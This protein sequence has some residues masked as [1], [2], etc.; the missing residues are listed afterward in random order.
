MNTEKPVVTVTRKLPEKTERRMSE[1]FDARFNENDAPMTHEQLREAMAISDIL[2]VTITDMIDA[3]LLAG[4]GEKLKLIANFGAGTDHIDV[5]TARQ[6]NI[7]VT[8]TPDVFAEDTADLTMAMLLALPRRLLEGVDA[9]RSRKWHGWSP[10]WMT[11]SRPAGKH[12][13][14]IGLG[15]VGEAVA[16]RAAAFGLKIHYH[17]PAPLP[18]KLAASLGAVYWESLDQLLAHADIVSVHCTHTPAT[19]H[20]LSARRLDL[21]KKTA[22]LINTSRGEV[23]DE[24]ALLRKLEKNEIAGAA[25]DVYE[26]KSE[27]DSRFYNLNNVLLLPHMCSATLEGRQEAG[28]RLILNIQTFLSG[29]NPPD[30]VFS[31]HR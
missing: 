4:A 5:Q 1:L 3:T 21:L 23:I 20:L 29:H 30:R 11:G 17:N 18:E 26:R 28:D 9:I 25:L 19:Y 13:A 27:F 12:L 24:A 22:Y 2:A 7:L 16:R 31:R 15:R 10:T 8:N 6:R 14:I